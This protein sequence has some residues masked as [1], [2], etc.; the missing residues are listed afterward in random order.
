[1]DRGTL[2]LIIIVT[3]VVTALVHLAL[4]LAG[5]FGGSPGS[6]D[7]LFVLNG[8]GYLA[9][10]AALFVP[11]VPVFATNRSLAHYLMVAFAG[12]TFVLYFMFNGFS[13]LG[14]AAAISK[15]AEL[16]LMASTWRH[17]KAAA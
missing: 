6:L 13:N 9:L 11:N 1:M 10:L 4:G 3:A 14:A 5:V 17:L 16:L 7:Y 2:R 15:L 12:M 8:L